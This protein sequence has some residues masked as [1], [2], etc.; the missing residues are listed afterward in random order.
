MG[1]RGGCEGLT[2]STRARHTRGTRERLRTLRG[3]FANALTT[4]AG[5]QL[6]RASD[7]VH[8][9]DYSFGRMNMP[10]LL[11]IFLTISALRVSAFGFVA[12]IWFCVQ[13]DPGFKDRLCLLSEGN[14]DLGKLECNSATPSDSFA[15]ARIY[16]DIVEFC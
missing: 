15:V 2:D 5:Q 4:I 10:F 14:K 7:V 13:V 6:D 12:P 11:L 16:C 8:S 1:A 9:H 3:R